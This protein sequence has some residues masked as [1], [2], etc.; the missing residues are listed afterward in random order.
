MRSR[1][2]GLLRR[3][4]GPVVAREAGERAS[5]AAPRPPA[6]RLVAAAPRPPDAHHPPRH[7]EAECVHVAGRRVLAAAARGRRLRRGARRAAALRGDGAAARRCRALGRPG[8]GCLALRGPASSDLVSGHRA[9]GPLASARHPKILRAIVHRL[10]AGKSAGGFP[11]LVSP[12]PRGGLPW[13]P[14]RGAE[15]RKAHLCRALRSRL[16]RLAR[17]APPWRRRLASRRSTAAI[18][19]PGTVLPGPDR[20]RS[21]RPDPRRFPRGSSGPRPAFEGRPP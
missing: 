14:A 19:H 4:R 9:F 18:F 7:F 13:L 17:R 2:R 5:G 6:D 8:F 12:P 1:A 20:G 15:R 10:P 16:P 3:C 21:G 11:C